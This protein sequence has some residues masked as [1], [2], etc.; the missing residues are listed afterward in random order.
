M[1]KDLMPVFGSMSA[2]AVRRFR[3]RLDSLFDQFFEDFFDIDL[4]IFDN[5]QPKSSFPKVNVI[6]SDDAYEVDIA[7]AG[8]D[9]DDIKLE[10]KDNDLFIRG[11]K[12]HDQ[13]DETKR[14]LRREISSR[15]FKRIVR[16]PSKIDSDSIKAEYKNGIIKVNIK[17]DKF[18]EPDKIEIKIN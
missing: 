1:T 7:I 4:A 18:D 17:K 11:N 8:F 14:F 13:H 2:P 5:L 6:E 3:D 16:L 10:L 9:K 12:Q 15:S